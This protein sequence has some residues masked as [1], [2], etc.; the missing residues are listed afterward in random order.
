MNSKHTKETTSKLDTC[1]KLRA[2][3]PYNA[4]LVLGYITLDFG[5][6]GANYNS[7]LGSKYLS[8]LSLASLGFK[9]CKELLVGK[10]SKSIDF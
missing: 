3:L 5:A 9:N 10:P 8:T 7:W 4:M 2:A 6:D 1:P